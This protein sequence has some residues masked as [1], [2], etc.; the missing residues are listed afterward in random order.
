VNRN[1]DIFRF[2]KSMIAFRKAH[3]SLGRSRFS[4]EEISWYGVGQAADL[5]YNSHTLSFCLRG[6]SQQDSDLYVM[7]NAFWQD[8]DFTVQEGQPGEWKRIADTGL[9]SPSDFIESSAAVPLTNATYQVKSRSVVV[10]ER[11][12]Q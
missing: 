2:F 11:T 6:A 9:P 1:Q 12:R 8:L 4:R 3:P 10:L 7:I 5:S